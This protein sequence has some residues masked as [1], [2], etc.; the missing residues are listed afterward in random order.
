MMLYDLLMPDWLLKADAEFRKYDHLLYPPPELT[1]IERL[2]LSVSRAAA[3]MVPVFQKA[4]DDINRAFENFGK[5][6]LEA[7]QR[8]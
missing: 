1:V 6:Y 7:Q 8:R 5:A 3:L 4:T 2:S